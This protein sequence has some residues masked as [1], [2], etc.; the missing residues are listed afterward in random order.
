VYADYDA[1]RDAFRLSYY[2]S[3]ELR[4]ST[5]Q[6]HKEDATLIVDSEEVKDSTI[7]DINIHRL[8]YVGIHSLIHSYVD[9]EELRDSTSQDYKEYKAYTV[10]SKGVKVS[11]FQDHSFTSSSLI[12]G[13]SVRLSVFG[14]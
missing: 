3:E 7:Q 6:D 10:D 2:D 11:T 9:S 5:S 8:S 13:N 12:R 14:K 1:F 4:D